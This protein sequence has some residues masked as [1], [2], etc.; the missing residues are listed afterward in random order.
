MI[1]KVS[2]VALVGM[3]GYPIE[4]EAS[5]SQGLPG[6]NIVGLP[7]SSVQEARERVR[8]AIVASG[9]PWPQTRITVNLSPAHLRKSGSAFDLAIAVAILI[10]QER[11]PQR[12]VNGVFVLGE[13]SLDGIVQR[14]RGVLPAVLAAH[15]T[16][17]RSVVVP[18]ANAAE[19]ALVRRIRVF[20]TRTLAEAVAHLRGDAVLKPWNGKAVEPFALESDVDLSDVRGNDLT[21]RALEIAA[22]G[23][24]NMLM[25]GSAGAGKTMLARRLPTILPP[26][27]EEEAFEVT[28]VYSVAGLVPDGA[29]LITRRP[30]RAPHHTSSTAGIVGGGQT[31]AHPGECSLAHRGVLF[32]D[33]L[34]EFRSE[35]LQSLR[36][37]LE[38][39]IVTIVRSRFAN[40]FPAR[41]QLV[42][43]S[44][45]CPCGN[46]GDVL[47]PC[48]CAPARFRGYRERLSGPVLDRIDLQVA[49]QRL[50]KEELFQT[51][52]GES[53]ARVAARVL[54][55]R[56]LQ[57][58][59]KRALSNAELPPRDLHRTVRLQSDGR[60]LLE[61]EV[62]HRALSARSAHRI[63]RVAR[64]IADLDEDEIVGE[65]HILNA[66]EFR[67]L[68]V[69]TSAP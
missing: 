29:G 65:G 23:G 51:P 57:T 54:R 31:L 59:R 63:L 22:A 39:G 43:A 58:S 3:V 25:I 62:D 45:P 37:P 55:A 50:R 52:E 14:V 34:A 6:F 13:L 47:K 41:F 35:T 27:T 16:R 8:S 48:V 24:H 53:S 38:D 11:I 28:R 5:V 61:A 56:E 21:K 20:P 26:M 30:F 9:E 64:T 32:L 36:Q 66:L 44:N 17:A 69:V 15:A 33:E 42:A 1:A 67:V 2:S 68:D 7:D 10:A 4:V 46:Y 18:P 60:R 19:A 40:T 12:G 49:V